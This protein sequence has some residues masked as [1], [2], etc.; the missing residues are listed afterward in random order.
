MPSVVWVLTLFL[1]TRRN[2]S[3]E[4]SASSH[5][6]WMALRFGSALAMRLISFSLRLLF[7]LLL[8]SRRL[9]TWLPG[10]TRTG[11]QTSWNRGTE[12]SVRGTICS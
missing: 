11:N 10:N 12:R 9:L 5:L 4:T 6:T 1:L 2:E 3:N 8:P 7:S